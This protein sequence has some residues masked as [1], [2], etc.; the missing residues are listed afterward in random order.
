MPCHSDEKIGLPLMYMLLSGYVGSHPGSKKFFSR[1]SGFPGP[2]R[3]KSMFPNSSFT[4]DLNVSGG[5]KEQLF[6]CA[7]ICIT[8]C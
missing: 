8:C 7:T 6:G 1:Y 5:Q 4:A 2:S 3:Q